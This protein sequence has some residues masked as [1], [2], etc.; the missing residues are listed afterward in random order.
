MPFA[1]W[2]EGSTWSFGAPG[3][4]GKLSRICH[5]SLAPFRWHWVAVGTVRQGKGTACE[6]GKGLNAVGKCPAGYAPGSAWI[7]LG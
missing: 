5:A 6:Y 7:H 2:I 4:L 1:K 3:I